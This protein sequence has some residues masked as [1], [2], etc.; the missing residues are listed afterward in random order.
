MS[1]TPEPPGNDSIV[2][3]CKEDAP[4]CRC[5]A[6]LLK[7]APCHFISRGK[8]HPGL[9]R[10]ERGPY[11]VKLLSTKFRLSWDRTQKLTVVYNLIISPQKIRFV[12]I[13]QNNRYPHAKLWVSQFI[14][15]R[16]LGGKKWDCSSRC[17]KSYIISLLMH[18]VKIAGSSQTN[19]KNSPFTWS[20]VWGISASQGTCKSLWM[21]KTTSC[22]LY[23]FATK[24]RAL[25]EVLKVGKWTSFFSLFCSLSFCF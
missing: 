25:M 7:C 22:F 23:G 9:A 4:P 14:W 18:S 2:R 3:R 21:E 8:R 12:N 24:Q 6:V 1:T 20:H 16:F 17:R 13:I 15:S 5:V 11:F 10:S 19:Y